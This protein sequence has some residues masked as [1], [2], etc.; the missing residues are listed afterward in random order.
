MFS[1]I[2][3]SVIEIISILDPIELTDTIELADVLLTL[4]NITCIFALL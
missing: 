1:I 4:I 2:S 3:T